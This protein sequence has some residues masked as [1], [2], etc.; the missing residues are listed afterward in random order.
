MNNRS[1]AVSRCALLV[2]LGSLVGCFSSSGVPVG[3]VTGVV[4]VGGEPMSDAT[5]TFYPE[6]GRPS[7]GMTDE[8]GHYDL[9]FTESVKGAIVGIHRV[10]ISYGGPP[11]PGEV[12]R[13]ARAKRVLPPT[14]VEWPEPVQVE[15]SSN[16]IDFDL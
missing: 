9:L 1:H 10:N 13:H 7:I 4:T 8:S 6:V 2:L 12:D 16:T 3:K 5:V 14:N 15:S 11:Q